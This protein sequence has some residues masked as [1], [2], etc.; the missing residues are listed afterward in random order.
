MK[1]VMYGPRAVGKTSFMAKG[2]GLMNDGLDAGFLSGDVK[3]KGP[4]AL[5]NMYKQ[6][7]RGIYPDPTNKLNLY[8]LELK[9]G[10]RTVLDFR[11]VDIVGGSIYETSEDY[12]MVSN[13]AL[14]ADALMLFH[15][16]PDLLS[17]GEET[18]DRNARDISALTRIA[19][20]HHASN[21]DFKLY[22]V[23]TKCDMASPSN[24][25]I[26]D[27]VMGDIMAH[28]DVPVRRFFVTCESG[29]RGKSPD[30][31]MYSVFL[32][33]LYRRY[34]GYGGEKEGFFSRRNIKATNRV[35]SEWMASQTGDRS[36]IVQNEACTR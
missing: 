6:M 25:R 24:L 7:R 5:E 19:E 26:L 22:Q 13:T 36:W 34:N 20:R 9:K 28:V 16:C 30:L 4:K 2:Y 35:I 29:Y 15:S 17:G 23:M 33:E 31:V 18:I 14:G 10:L 11:W 12:S 32:D 27:E 1:V 3:L 8:E 21:P